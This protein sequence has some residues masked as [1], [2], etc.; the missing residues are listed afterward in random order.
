MKP[1]ESDSVA[2]LKDNSKALNRMQATTGVRP[3]GVMWASFQLTEDQSPHLIMDHLHLIFSRPMLL[4]Q[5][6]PQSF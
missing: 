2:V 1:L 4:S 3:K 6:L 5:T